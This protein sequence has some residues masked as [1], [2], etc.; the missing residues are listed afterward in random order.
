MNNV[1]FAFINDDRRKE[2]D[3]LEK[4]VFYLHL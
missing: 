3:L 2:I 1:S 4:F